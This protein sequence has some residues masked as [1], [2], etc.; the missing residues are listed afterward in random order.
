MSVFSGEAIK[1]DVWR[2]VLIWAILKVSG[3]TEIGEASSFS[4]PCWPGT[5]LVLKDP[6]RLPLF[7]TEKDLLKDLL[8]G[9]TLKFR[10]SDETENWAQL[11]PKE[12]ENYF[13]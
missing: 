13:V 10:L 1:L 12:Q 8:V 2:C 4:A 9:M 11:I 3:L 5:T 7:V 6:G